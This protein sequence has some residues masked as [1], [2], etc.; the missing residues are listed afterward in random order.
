MPAIFLRIRLTQEQQNLRFLLSL[1]S[2]VA[3]NR[4]VQFNHS[5]Q[6]VAFDQRLQPQLNRTM[7]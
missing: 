5:L 3:A 6:I 2:F 7:E 1:Q 4:A